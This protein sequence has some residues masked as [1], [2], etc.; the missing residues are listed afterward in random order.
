MQLIA[1]VSIHFLLLHKL[2][3]YKKSIVFMLFNKSNE[4][5]NQCTNWYNRFIKKEI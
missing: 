1:I 3:S 5:Y 2:V 4:L